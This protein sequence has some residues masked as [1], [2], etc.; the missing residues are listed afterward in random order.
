M[1]TLLNII[2]HFPLF[3]FLS[4]GTCYLL[5]LL[6]VVTVIGAPIGTGLMEYAKFLMAPFSKSMVTK[7]DLQIEENEAW[8]TYGTIVTICYLPFGLMLAAVGVIQA[9]FLCITVVG[10]PF[11]AIIAKSMTTIINPVNKK[12]VSRSAKAELDRR[13]GAAEIDALSS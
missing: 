12:C 5:G 9:L 8:K 6:L 3:G 11:A 1:R 13:K 7:K 2:W 10:I 4:A